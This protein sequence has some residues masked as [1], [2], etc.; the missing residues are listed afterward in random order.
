MPIS[1]LIWFTK[2]KKNFP[3]FTK[4]VPDVYEK[5]RTSENG[6][7]RVRLAGGEKKVSSDCNRQMS[8]SNKLSDQN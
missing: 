3:I 1:V 5:F 2:V 4:E 6:I 7:K 8:I